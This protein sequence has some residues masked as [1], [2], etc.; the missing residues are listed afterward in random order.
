MS[1]TRINEFQAKAGQIDGLH[2]F[3]IS[4]MPIIQS[5]NG[6]ESCQLLQNQDDPTRFIVLEVWVSAEAHKTS[7]KNVSPEKFVKIKPLLAGSPS[8]A[9]YSTA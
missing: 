4:I 7:L 5:S 6:C 1:I 9:Y 2:E 3:L 8:G